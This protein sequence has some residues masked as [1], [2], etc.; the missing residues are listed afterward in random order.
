MQNKEC[1]FLELVMIILSGPSQ[2]KKWP[3]SGRMTIGRRQGAVDVLINDTKI[4]GKHALAEQEEDGK[5]VLRDLGSKNQIKVAGEKFTKILLQP[6]IE[7][8]LGTTKIRVVAAENAQA[9]E[10]LEEEDISEPPAAEAPA[11]ED[12]APPAEAKPGSAKKKA[13]L[14]QDVR[15][16]PGIELDPLSWRETLV[17]TL[18]DLKAK[19]EPRPPAVSAL[20]P[21]VKLEFERGPQGEVEWHLGYGPRKIGK[22]SSELMILDR[23]APDHCFEI[24]PSMEG[25]MFRTNNPDKV[26][27]NGRPVQAQVLKQNDKIT[28]ARTVIKVHLK[29]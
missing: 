21:M 13:P 3:L 26:Q 16:R 7:F 22:A 19:V 14:G 24:V 17:H 25:P 18:K 9:P 27:L 12:A 20:E 6:G 23:Q 29:S 15:T 10:G 1:C 4:S 2:G 11:T 8:V 28:F 5:W